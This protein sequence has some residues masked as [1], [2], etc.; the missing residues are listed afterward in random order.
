MLTGAGMITVAVFSTLLAFLTLF[1]MGK[2]ERKVFHKNL[3]E[4][5]SFADDYF[6]NFM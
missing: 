2:L 1:M 3:K 6:P 5:E 4:Q